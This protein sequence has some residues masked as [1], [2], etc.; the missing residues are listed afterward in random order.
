MTAS[1]SLGLLVCAAAVAACSRGGSRPATVAT[2]PAAAAVPT[3]SMVAALQAV[4]SPV[5]GTVQLRPGPTP[6][7]IRAAIRIRDSAAGL[8]HRWEIRPG[9]CGAPP[10]ATTLAP[11]DAF[12]VLEVRADGTAEVEAVLPMAMPLRSA[13]HVAVLRSRGDD[14]VIACGMLSPEG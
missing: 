6:Q 1:R 8:V 7:Q 4:N 13:H 2:A 5:T 10:A 12:R 3:T 14:T 11:A 9:T